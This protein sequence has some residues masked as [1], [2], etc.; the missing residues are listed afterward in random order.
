[1]DYSYLLHPYSN[2]YRIDHLTSFHVVGD[3]MG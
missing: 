3:G 1:M 2:L